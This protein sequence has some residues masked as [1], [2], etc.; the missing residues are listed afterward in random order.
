MKQLK[1]SMKLL[2]VLLTLIAF[3]SLPACGEK[4]QAATPEVQKVEKETI[5]WCQDVR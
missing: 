5:V 4:Q 1:H 2:A 3:V